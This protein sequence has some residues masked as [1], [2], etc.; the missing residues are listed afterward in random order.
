MSDENSTL[1]GGFG[2]FAAGST[3]SRPHIINVTGPEKITAWEP[4]TGASKYKVNPWYSRLKF[5]DIYGTDIDN[6]FF[7]QSFTMLA[8]QDGKTFTTT[9][10][11]GLIQGG[12]PTVLKVLEE[13]LKSRG[14]FVAAQYLPFAE[15]SDYRNWQYF[16]D[17]GVATVTYND[18][19]ASVTIFALNQA[20]RDAIVEALRPLTGKKRSAGKCFVM[21]SSPNGIQMRAVSGSAKV[22]FEPD[23]YSEDTAKKFRYMVEQ[24]KSDTPNGRIMIF[25]GEP[26][27]GKTYLIRSLVG[28]VERA[29]FVVVPAAM[30]GELD[31][32]NLIGTLINT[33]SNA[34]GPIVLILEDA[35]S[36]LAP[37]GADNMHSISSLL[38]LSDGILGNLMDLRI[39]ATTNALKEEL[40]SAVTRDGRLCVD[41]EVGAL[42]FEHANRVYKRLT[43]NADAE[44]FQRRD[45]QLAEVYKLSRPDTDTSLQLTTKK[46]SLGFEAGPAFGEDETV[47]VTS[48][49]P[50]L[51]YEDVAAKY[52]SDMANDMQ[53]NFKVIENG[54]NVDFIDVEGGLSYVPGPGPDFEDNTINDALDK[55]PTLDPAYDQVKKSS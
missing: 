11:E 8:L 26:G 48:K 55:N 1:T 45:Y 47:V 21:A 20:D 13:K 44:L 16:W 49:P 50:T 46:G 5:A 17:E 22:A 27:G 40:D 54:D 41:I 39:I 4:V 7:I 29:I 31:G 19:D 12:S 37:R 51:S 14:G 33:Y 42:D 23:N 53:G 28:A 9:Q 52:G 6:R 30:V 32:P 2:V 18:D 36:V 10:F 35:D 24:L 25:R 43:G 34:D 15:T 3:I 38:N